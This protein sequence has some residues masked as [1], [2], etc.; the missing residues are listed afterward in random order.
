MTRGLSD[1]KKQGL[2]DFL[3]WLSQ[4]EQQAFWHRNTGYFPISNSAVDLL[5]EDGWFEKN[6]NFQTAFD[7]LQET[8]TTVATRGWQAGPAS[9]VRSI[10]QD[11]YVSMINSDVGVDE[12]LG[13]MKTEA[14]TALQDYIDSKGN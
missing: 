4:P 9:K 8:E 11:G 1:V 12:K 10:I 2:A 7:Q 6:P 5:E 13:E 14:D 3:S